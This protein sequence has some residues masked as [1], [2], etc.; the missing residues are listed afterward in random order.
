MSQLLL[1]AEA[2]RGRSIAATA[3]A[4]ADA[5][6]ADAARVTETA[7]AAL[8]KYIPTE[9][10]TLYIATVS[11]LPAMQG[12][13]E[14]LTSNHLYYGFAI[15]TPILFVLIFFNQLAVDQKPYP[16]FPQWPWWRIF[17]STV[18]FCVWALAV[19]NN[20]FLATK[21]AGVLAGLGAAFVSMLLS[22]IGPIVERR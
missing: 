7:I 8:T 10:I 3:Q 2:A 5:T 21:T 17:A 9:V 18:A 12:E 13:W 6:P 16:A 15:L 22:I 1:A 20:P 19:P 4:A 11:A 14:S